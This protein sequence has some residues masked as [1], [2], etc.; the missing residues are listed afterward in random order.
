MPAVTALFALLFYAA[1]VVLVGGLFWKIRQYARTPAPLRIPTTP[2][3]T[4]R[5]GVAMR[6]AR[7]VALFESLFKSNKWIGWALL[8][9]LC[10]DLSVRGSLGPA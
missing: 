6:M 10:A 2:A 3:P 4:T 5:A 9:G 1:S 7:E 8:A